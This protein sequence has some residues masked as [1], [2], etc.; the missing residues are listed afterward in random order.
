[1]QATDR[2]LSVVQIR[3]GARRRL[4]FDVRR[5]RIVALAPARVLRPV[6]VDSSIHFRVVARPALLHATDAPAFDA[7]RFLLL[8]RRLGLCAAVV[9]DGMQMLTV[10]AALHEGRVIF[11]SAPRRR[12]SGWS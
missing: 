3:L 2:G 10:A 4:I 9:V 6:V 1:M 8:I 7:S 12:T 5:L 11:Q